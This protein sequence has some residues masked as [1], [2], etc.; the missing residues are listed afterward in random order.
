MTTMV[1]FYNITQHALDDHC[2]DNEGQTLD[3]RSSMEEEDC[4]QKKKKRK[5]RSAVADVTIVKRTQGR[6]F[7]QLDNYTAR[8]M[9]R[10]EEDGE[11]ERGGR[12]VTPVGG[13]GVG[14]GG[15]GRGWGGGSLTAHLSVLTVLSATSGGR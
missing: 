13:T 10:E 12:M 2:Y 6:T 1:K 15:G 3:C 5:E 8:R 4:V 9:G 14:R 11:R 7:P